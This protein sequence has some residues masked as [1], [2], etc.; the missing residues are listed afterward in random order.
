VNT[1]TVSATIIRIILALALIGGLFIAGWNIYRRLP[2]DASDAPADEMND[3]RAKTQLKIVIGNGLPDAA[4][5]SSFDLYRFDLTAAKREFEATGRAG[6]QF[7]DFLARRMQGVTS[8]KA[9]VDNKG[10]AIAILNDG[11]WWLHAKASFPN[12]ERF[13]WR[14]PVRVSGA[15]QTVELTVENAY[16]RTMKF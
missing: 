12:G 7:D 2:V 5:Y 13:E 15:E 4:L 9:I 11:D 10:R 6:K 1:E 3:G 8:Q 16:E 14:L